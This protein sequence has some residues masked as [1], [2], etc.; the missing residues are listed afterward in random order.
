LF[1][2]KDSKLQ[3]IHEK[4]VLDDLYY[5]KAVLPTI[6]NI[7]TYIA[8]YPNNKISKYFLNMDEAK[9]NKQLLKL[10][11]AISKIGV[12]I[13]LYD[14]YH[15]NLYLINRENIY[16]RVIYQ[17]YR[18]PEKDI[19]DSFQKKYN[20]LIKNIDDLTKLELVKFNKL[21]LMIAFLKNFDLTILKSTYIHIFY[22]YANEVGKNLTFCKRPS[23]E[24][25]FRHIKPYYSRSEMINFALNAGI[26]EDNNIYYDDKKIIELCEPIQENDIS[27]ETLIAHQKYIISEDKV[28]IVQYYSFQGSYFMNQYQRQMTAYK[29][30][31]N[32]LEGM[33]KSMWELV[34]NAPAFDKS[35]ILYRF[36]ETDSHLKSIRVG[37]NYIE[38]GFT[39]T[40]RD[41]FYR[42]DIYKFGFILVKIKIPEKIKGVALCIETLS[43]FPSEEEII[44]SPLSVLRLDRKDDNVPY[45]HTD[46]SFKSQ[47]K[48]RYEFT[49]IGKK[50][51]DFVD[52]P[53]YPNL[54]MVDFLKIEKIQHMTLTL[55]E[56]I[57]FF[58]KKYV[59]PMYTFNTKIGS[60][61][62]T[63]MA[64]WYD[65]TGPYKDFYAITS[66]NGFSIYSM[67]K[68][69]VLFIIELGESQ[70]D[71]YMYVNY[72]LRYSSIYKDVVFELDDF[73]KFLS[74]IV[75]YFEIKRT[76]V[77]SDY[78]LCDF[79]SRTIVP[80]LI[81]GNYCID[82]Y[83]Y[84]KYNKKRYIDNSILTM[85]IAPKFAYSQLD[86]LKMTSADK[87]LVKS[88]KDELYQ[89]YTKIYKEIVDS[90][91]PNNKVVEQ[92]DVKDNYNY[93]DNI[94]DFY[95]WVV[96]NHCYE[97][98]QLINKMER[99]F[100]INNPFAH[101]Y[102]ILNASTYLYNRNAIEY[103]PNFE[104]DT[105]T[106]FEFGKKINSDSNKNEY[107]LTQTIRSTSR[108]I[109]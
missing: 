21:K 44:L 4:N 96:D 39:S 16:Y 43:L 109:K 52:R 10:Q 18:F 77:F 92:N 47:I 20:E 88:D 27:K 85:E 23:F 32:Y 3:L 37:D 106:I 78:K 91:N 98:S 95:L 84:L 36:I 35:Y 103:F 38:K 67:Y 59:S 74:T 17:D 56:K 26:I 15:D 69:Y 57:K 83:D 53:L 8:A 25:R 24:P 2:V 89:I 63:C 87:I 70:S 104:S 9:I 19:F 51:I 42:S 68:N 86:K 55:N 34:N 54:E 28:G 105:D 107:R 61:E 108:F 30:K 64:E 60:T 101:D 102:Y 22:Y 75:F 13:P 100:I 1:Y 7:Q 79:T 48:T 97:I 14:P 65:S 31:N 94:A 29:Y 99:F 73:V 72:Y 45:Y 50:T 58:I 90:N 11:K 76:V 41:P 62:F 33:I 12:K 49:Y 66:N 82:F 80:K 93:K 40:T 6:K 81:G 71:T 46:D 5:Q